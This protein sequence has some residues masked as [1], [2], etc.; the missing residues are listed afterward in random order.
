VGVPPVDVVVPLVPPP[1]ATKAAS[2]AKTSKP[3]ASLAR[4]FFAGNSSRRI[5]ANTAPALGMSQRGRLNKRNAVD[6]AVVFTVSV[7]AALVV[8]LESVTEFGA[9]EQLL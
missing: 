4:R 9:R 3:K 6:G 8:V 5:Q 7:V 2:K 1:Q